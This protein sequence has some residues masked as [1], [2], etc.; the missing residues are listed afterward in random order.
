MD[1][2]GWCKKMDKEVFED[3][4]IRLELD[5]YYDI[6]CVKKG[7][8]SIP[9]FI[10]T[11]FYPTTFILSNDGK[12]IIEDIQGYMKPSKYLRYLKTLYE[13]ENDDEIE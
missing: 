12:E 10:H 8:S 7:S 4:E 2:C 1:Y 3:K 9:S 13:I 5:K 6:K 11:K